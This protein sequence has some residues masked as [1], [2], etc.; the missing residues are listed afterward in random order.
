MSV[1]VEDLRS[2]EVAQLLALNN[3]A[4]PEVNDLAL[5]EFERIRAMGHVRVAR[6]PDVSQAGFVLTLPPDAPYWSTNYHW[7]QERYGRFLY[8]DRVIVDVVTRGRGVG[9]ALYEDT[10]SYALTGGWERVVSEVNTVPPNPG[11]MAFHAA[12]GFATV[13][14][15]VN[16]ASG[17]SVAMMMLD[18]RGQSANQNV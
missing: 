15:R 11:S 3:L 1:V 7:F 6:L 4:T 18:L 10:I 5:E 2:D 8:V 17:K 16:E 12:L 14:E 9:R 13:G